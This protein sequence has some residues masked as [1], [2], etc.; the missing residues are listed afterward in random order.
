MPA[1]FGP[2]PVPEIRSLEKSQPGPSTCITHHGCGRQVVIWAEMRGT[3]S[4]DQSGGS[5]PKAECR[6][7]RDI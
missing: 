6:D 3:G 4:L 7:V 2:N 1:C 5:G